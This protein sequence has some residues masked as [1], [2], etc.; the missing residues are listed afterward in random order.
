[1]YRDRFL[2]K[3]IV[4]AISAV[5][6]FPAMLGQLGKLGPTLYSGAQTEKAQH[7]PVLT[8]KRKEHLL[9]GDSSGGGHLYGTGHACKSEFP[10]GWTEEDVVNTVTAL[11]ANDNVDWQKQKNGNH[12]AEVE[13]SGLNIR[14]V[15]SRDKSE[16]ITAYPLNGHRNPCG[17]RAAND[18]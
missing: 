5:L 18:N 2:K 8:A 14:I 17:G 12:V 6:V 16:I 10:E 9:H 4:F 15:L 1:M 7:A 3:I 11:A 13:H